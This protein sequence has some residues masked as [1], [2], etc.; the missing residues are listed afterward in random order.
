MS[1]REIGRL[2]ALSGALAAGIAATTCCVLPMVFLW[3]GISGAWIANL[4]AFSSYHTVFIC[5]SLILLATSYY[6]I[7]R[8]NDG[9]CEE[10]E[11]CAKPLPSTLVKSTFWITA[12]IICI[13][14]FFPYL[15]SYYYG[16]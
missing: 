3:A 11:V 8:R 1:E 9:E 2:S 12:I 4:T 15:V 10:G 5:I 14:A 6:F 7:Y 13:A 16:A